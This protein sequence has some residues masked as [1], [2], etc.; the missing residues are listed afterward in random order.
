MLHGEEVILRWNLEIS[1][2]LQNFPVKCLRIGKLL[3]KNNQK[4][5]LKDFSYLPPENLPDT[6]EVRVSMSFDFSLGREAHGL[7][8]LSRKSW[9]VQ[10][11]LLRCHNHLLWTYL[12]LPA[13]RVVQR[14]FSYVTKVLASEVCQSYQR[15]H[16]N[17]SNSPSV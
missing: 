14:L 9:L 8:I 12:V 2:F 13:C 11:N 5:F 16:S 17:R 1:Y 3:T 6:A 15:E 10:S 7:L 4:A